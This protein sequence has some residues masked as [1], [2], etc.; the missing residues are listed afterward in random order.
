M[1]QAA[2]NETAQRRLNIL[3]FGLMAVTAIAFAL[4]AALAFFATLGNIV[5]TVLIGLGA[6]IVVA[7]VSVLIYRVYKSAVLKA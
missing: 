4:A 1:S 2:T 6:G 5:T 3:R 7:I